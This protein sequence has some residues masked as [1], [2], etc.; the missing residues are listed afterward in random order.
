MNTNKSKMDNSCIFKTIVIFVIFNVV[1]S[2]SDG[3]TTTRPLYNAH[4]SSSPKQTASCN[5]VSSNLKGIFDSLTSSGIQIPSF[6]NN[7]SIDRF[8]QAR[9]LIRSLVEE[10]QCFSKESGAM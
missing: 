6:N 3:F 9:E 5:M 1:I 10:E 8:C 2:V 4:Q 7:E